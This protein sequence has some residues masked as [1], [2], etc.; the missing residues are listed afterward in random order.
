[1]GNPKPQ[2]ETR[3]S[4]VSRF[5]IVKLSSLGDVIHATPV[6]MTLR[7][8]LPDAHIAWLV[9]ETFAPLLEDH[10][11]L[12]AVIGLPTARWQRRL[13]G[14]R[15]LLCLSEGLDLVRRLRRG[16]Y[17]VVLE[18]QGLL[19]SGFWGWASGAPLR[20]AFAGA[21]ELGGV[22][23][24]L[25]LPK[26]MSFAALSEFYCQLLR[27]LGITGPFPAPAMPV[28]S[29]GRQWA[30]RWLDRYGIRTPPLSAAK[31][32]GQRANWQS[33]V[34]FVPCTTWPN[35]H[36]LPERFAAVSD[37][38]QQRFP[39]LRTLF[40]GASE[41]R[42]SVAAIR[43]HTQLEAL[44]GSGQTNLRQLA[45]L[46]E[47]CRLVIGVDSGPLHLAAAVGTPVVA[48][49]GPSNLMA[50]PQGSQHRLVRAP[51]E[52]AP[53]RRRPTCRNYDCMAAITVEQVVEAAAEVLSGSG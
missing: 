53:C 22:F 1:M 13:R 31:G 37:E 11:S 41:D 18:M 52:C 44:D 26:E 35:K 49:F 43:Q 12:D 10:P 39:G 15:P 23:H 50:M 27:P 6:A 17:D 36:W 28:G 42:P 45:A 24:N 47:R 19:R 32:K 25:R 20:I 5:L 4:Q 46:L 34:A 14:D 33:L 48:L 16:R 2:T 30:G 51:Y 9:D 7:H 40:V 3:E 21:R 29:A 38:L 8:H